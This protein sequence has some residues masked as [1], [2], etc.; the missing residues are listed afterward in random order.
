MV[1]NQGKGL[2]H[3]IAEI[4]SVELVTGDSPIS[5]KHGELD[6]SSTFELLCTR[7]SFRKSP[8][9]VMFLTFRGTPQGD[10]LPETY[11]RAELYSNLIEEVFHKD[12]DHNG[13]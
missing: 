2:K 3:S 4:R 7:E 11:W 8:R 13:A 9:P 12:V 5:S 1:D 10:S 6:F